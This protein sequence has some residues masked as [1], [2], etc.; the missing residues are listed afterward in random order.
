MKKSELNVLLVICV[1][2]F[3]LIAFFWW[4]GDQATE[5]EIFQVDEADSDEL[6]ETGWELLGTALDAETGQPIPGLEI[7]VWNRDKARPQEESKALIRAMTDDEGRF[8]FRNLEIG[9]LALDTDHDIYFA[10]GVTALHP[11]LEKPPENI[12]E[13]PDS[14]SVT[15]TK[16]GEPVE[17]PAQPA[18]DAPSANLREVTVKFRHGGAIR[19]MV[20]NAA[21][22]PC[23]GAF[24]LLAEAETTGPGRTWKTDAD[25][26]GAF[27]F[28]RL[29][30]G[31]KAE[32]TA[33]YRTEAPAVK[34]SMRIM[35]GEKRSITLTLQ[36]HAILTGTV[37]DPAGVP[38]PGALIFPCRSGPDREPSWAD[39]PLSERDKLKAGLI[40]RT[41]LDGSYR[42]TIGVAGPTTR[43][44]PAG[45]FVVAARAEGFLTSYSTAV[46]NT[47]SGPTPRT[48]DIQL[49]LS[50]A[51]SG[52]V[53]NRAHKPMAGVRV[54]A[55]VTSGKDAFRAVGTSE[56]NGAF[57]LSP[58]PTNSSS[59]LTFNA[60][61]FP[62]KTVAEV[63]ADGEPLVVIL[64]AGGSLKGTVKTAHDGKPVPLF[65]VLLKPVG[66]DLRRIEAGTG[67]DGGFSIDNLAAG[68]W[69]L[70]I[71]AD[72]YRTA[73]VR[74]IAIQ[75]GQ[76]AA[77][78]AVI[79]EKSTLISGTVH[80]NAEGGPLAGVNVTPVLRRSDGFV[81]QKPEAAVVTDDKGAFGLC[82]LE[83]GTWLLDLSRGAPPL[84]WRHGPIDLPAGGLIEG[85]KIVVGPSSGR[86]D[87]TV[88]GSDGKPHEDALVEV[89]VAGE[90]GLSSGS[91]RLAF[92]TGKG[93][94]VSIAAFSP[95]RKTLR[96]S[97]DR[98]LD[99]T[100]SLVHC[101]TRDLTIKKGE[102]TAVTV[103][104]AATPACRVFGTITRG[105]GQIGAGKV[106]AV[107]IVGSMPDMNIARRTVIDA[108]GN[109]AFGALPVG[110]Y[111]FYLDGQILEPLSRKPVIV[112]PESCVPASEQAP[113]SEQ[114]PASEQAKYGSMRRDFDVAAGL[115]SGTVINEATGKP[116]ARASVYVYYLA[117]DKTGV[118]G[119][120]VGSFFTGDD[121]AFS[122]P[123]LK[124]GEYNVAALG[125]PGVGHL[126]KLILKAGSSLKN[127]KIPL[128]PA[129]SLLVT[130]KDEGGKPLPGVM[131]RAE[132]TGSP[133]ITTPRQALCLTDSAG[134]AEIGPLDP[135]D[136]RVVIGTL[137]RVSNIE[138]AVKV[139]PGKTATVESPLKKGPQIV[140]TVQTKDGKPVKRCRLAVLGPG[141]QWVGPPVSGGLIA[142]GELSSS[143]GKYTLGGYAPG[144]F[145][146]HILAHGFRAKTAPVKI[147][148]EGAIAPL[149]VKLDPVQ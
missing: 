114:V 137:G 49:P 90:F 55:V 145:K 127:L 57:R 10:E 118:T 117:R 18:A 26:R 54:S 140:L 79:L 94:T 100:G 89:A 24:V 96:V 75:P 99:Q 13:P 149:V 83:P 141:N 59:T 66:T 52:T 14:S 71:A 76:E 70:A 92:R 12:P 38:V 67:T 102:T 51:I 11:L 20:I 32:L 64:D 29:P 135:G 17:P 45:A 19:G 139:E 31:L 146:V 65:R 4:L 84:V 53:Q 9:K 72:G 56:A 138:P 86:L 128:A 40:T 122:F 41:G 68:I 104:F 74:R 112:D 144:S 35:A 48:N 25:E 134:R 27:V 28:E 22:S 129:G 107:P 23:A 1:I 3:S 81:E 130:V 108:T 33:F 143:D 116:L 7:C 34:Q 85:Q 125:L 61:G 110:R 21:D 109:Y 115:I 8:R 111:L 121:G 62:E 131:V 77:P 5:K 142:R 132:K 124:N 133:I 16:A 136:Y 97:L 78:L 42:L 119:M 123:G 105:G 95:G 126:E 47:D 88:L 87:V 43:N 63:K 60:P 69:D 82:G 44:E 39:L 58:L 2:T 73:S 37:F 148:A 120:Q 91:V 36:P 46:T 98:E 15:G 101:E 93:G 30:P 103:S 147:P 50:G 106:A 80:A 113:A 6:L